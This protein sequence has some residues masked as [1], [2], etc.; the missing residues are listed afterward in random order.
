[1]NSVLEIAMY[2]ESVQNYAKAGEYY[3]IYGDHVRSLRFYILDGTDSGI[4][5]AINV[6]KKNMDKPEFEMMAHE[7]Q[8]YLTGET[9]GKPK[10]P[11]H[12]YRLQMALGDFVEAASTAVLI[13][14]QEQQ[15]GNYKVAHSLLLETHQDLVQ[16]NLSIPDELKRSLLLLHSYI[17]TKRLVALKDHRGAALMLLRV[18]KNISKF[19]SHV[20][21]ILTSAVIECQRADLKKSC[22][23]YACTLMRPEYRDQIPETFKAKIEKQVRRAPT[24]EDPEVL[25]ECPFCQMAIPD[26]TLDCPSCRNF[27]PYCITTGLHMVLDDWSMCP[28]CKFPSLYSAFYSAIETEQKYAIFIQ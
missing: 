9:D 10:D 5:G 12:M 25:T 1:M 3:G 27:I 7:L 13:A 26:S 20:V 15:F 16:Q 23:E 21:P 2:Y 11:Q 22:Y 8:D 24:E 28:S 6:L 19:P 17:L 14:A 4:E 18:V